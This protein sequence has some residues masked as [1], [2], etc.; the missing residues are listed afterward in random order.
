MIQFIKQ[1]G[2]IHSDVTEVVEKENKYFRFMV[3]TINDPETF[4]FF[5]C[6]TPFNP[7][8]KKDDIVKITGAIYTM[9]KDNN[10]FPC[11]AVK[12]LK[13]MRNLK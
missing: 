11:I 6:N 1:F 8:A 2:I 12:N 5:V 3:K 7:N 13:V 9:T 4:S 10:F